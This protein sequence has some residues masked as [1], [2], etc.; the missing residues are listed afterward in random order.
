MPPAR[1]V[2]YA[3]TTGVLACTAY[4]IVRRPPPVP[5]A[6]AMLLAYASLLASGVLAH[7]LR[8]FVDAVVR[9]PKGARGVALTFDGGPDPR[10]T[11]RVLDLLAGR[12]ARAT[13]FVVAEKAERHADVLRAV[14]AAGHAIGLQSHAPDRLF[15]LRSE[16][17]VRSDLEHGLRALEAL[18]GT[19]PVLFRPPSGYTNPA[20]ARVADSL[21]LVVVGWTIGARDGRPGARSDMVASRVCRDLRDGAIVHLHDAPDRAKREPPA[22]R[23]L[24]RILDGLALRRL[25]AVSLGRWTELARVQPPAGSKT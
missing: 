25:E 16:R 10:W 4:S 2:L 23:A 6:G 22:V 7:P 13:F 1:L 21:G 20:I 24:P 3:S 17:R 12:G 11:P 19:R 9:G 8:T 18:L 5:W 14:V 15:C